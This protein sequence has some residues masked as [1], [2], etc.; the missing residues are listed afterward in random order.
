[1]KAVCE[2]EMVLLQANVYFQSCVYSTW[3]TAEKSPD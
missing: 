1:M 2:A 3:S